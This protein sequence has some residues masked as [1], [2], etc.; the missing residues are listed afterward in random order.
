MYPIYMKNDHDS[1]NR[2]KIQFNSMG[3]GKD[4]QQM[5][6]DQLRIQDIISGEWN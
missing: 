3:K 2:Q 5:V 1:I 6:L 4:F